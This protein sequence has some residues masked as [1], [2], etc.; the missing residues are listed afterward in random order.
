MKNCFYY[1]VP[2]EKTQFD[3]QLMYGLTHVDN[4]ITAPK[5]Q[6]LQ[7]WF[8]SMMRQSFLPDAGCPAARQRAHW[9]HSWTGRI[10]MWLIINVPKC[11]TFLRDSTHFNPA[12]GFG[13]KVK[14]VTFSIG[15]PPK[16]RPSIWPILRPPPPSVHLRS[17]LQ[18]RNPPHPILDVHQKWKY[19]IKLTFDLMQTKYAKSALISDF[20]IAKQLF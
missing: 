9:L 15:S 13:T 16:L 1:F 10:L 7:V 5:N 3:H 4:D 18:I 8:F 12:I 20:K 14:F 17:S 11:D 19:S 2:D 6:K